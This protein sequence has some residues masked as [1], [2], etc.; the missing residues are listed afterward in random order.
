MSAFDGG[1]A[2]RGR[3]EVFIRKELAFVSDRHKSIQKAVNTVFPEA[4][5]AICMRHLW[6]NV[7]ANF[8]K[9]YI[10]PLFY[11]CAKAY[12]VREFEYW[13]NILS[14]NKIKI[15]KYILK[16]NP[17]LWARNKFPEKRFN[18]KTTNI[19]EC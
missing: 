8:S 13:L 10:Q 9:T 14:N 11:R 17:E 15:K 18:V 19:S 12:C 16:A 5:F 6:G 2:S 7:K 3:V 4:N 1:M